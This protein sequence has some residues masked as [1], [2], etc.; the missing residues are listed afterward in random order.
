MDSTDLVPLPPTP[1]DYRSPTLAWPVLAD[2]ERLGAATDLAERALDS[3]SAPHLS[4]THALVIVQSGR[5]VYEHYG[6]GWSSTRPLLSWSVA[7]SFTQALVGFLVA[8]GLVQLDQPIGAPEWAGDDPRSAI[9]WQDLLA[10]R[11]G[12]RFVEDYVDEG[13]SD[14]LAM[15]SRHADDMA[16]FAASLPL[17]AEIGASFNYS[18]GTTNILCRAAA[19]ALGPDQSVESY[20]RERLFDPMG[21]GRAELTSDAAGTWTGSSFLYLTAR[22]YLRFGELYL[23]GGW[24]DGTQLLPPGW[25]DRARRPLSQDP[26]NGVYYGEHWWTFGD[27]YGSFHANGFDGQAIIVV[28]GLDVVIARFG[29]T[30]AEQHDD[31]RQFYRD[32]IAAL[33]PVDETG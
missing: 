25:V 30:P 22:D 19:A 9:T 13:G 6:P 4:A 18:S 17:E 10:M 5:I 32:L 33:G 15:L 7:K 28:P 24:W 26:E 21:V 20:L 16:A 11:S 29:K 1:S 27:E 2:S 3:R 14:C 8:D 31:L 12:L 23:R